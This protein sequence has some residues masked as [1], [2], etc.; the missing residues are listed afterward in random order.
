MPDNPLVRELLREVFESNRTPEDVCAS[1]PDLLTEVRHQLKRVRNLEAQLA[2]LFPSSVDELATPPVT[3]SHLSHDLPDIPGYQVE[4][5]I[6]QG[7]MGVVLRA[8][9]LKLNR[10]IALKM[11]LSGAFASRPEKAR[12][13]REAE[14]VATLSHPHIVQIYDVGELERRPFFTME[15][16]E[17]GSLA[18]QLA[19]VP[20]PAT[21]SAQLTATLALAVAYAHQ[22]GV[23]H[24][25][26]K[27][28]NI[29]HTSDNTPK[30]VDFGLARLDDSTQDLTLSGA[31]LG[32]PSY[33]SPE[34]ARGSTRDIG[35]PTDIY[36]LGAILYEM[37]T[38]R[39]PFRADTAAETVRQVVFEEPA[40]PSRLNASVPR[41][42]ETICLK[43]L[44]KPLARRYSSATEVA[45][46][47]QRFLEGQPILARPV[48]RFVRM[49]KWA[50]RR[51]AEAALAALMVL[52]L[53]LAVA[54]GFWF[55][56]QRSEQR[57]VLARQEGRASQALEDAL[58]NAATYQDQGSWPTAYGTLLDAE[59]FLAESNNPVLE[60]TFRQACQDAAT[61]TALED[62]RM[63]VVQARHSR[64][65]THPTAGQLYANAFRRYGI[66]VSSRS[67]DATAEQI[68]ESKIREPLLTFLHDWLH[69]ASDVDRNELEA[70]L[71]IA[72]DNQWRRSMR[73]A[74]VTDNSNQLNTLARTPNAAIQPAIVFS[75]LASGLR[76]KARSEDVLSLLREV[77]RRHTEDFWIH[78]L[79]GDYLLQDNPL[80]AVASLTA[81]VSIRPKSVHAYLLLGRALRD[82]GDATGAITAFRMAIALDPASTGAQDMAN[83]LTTRAD[84][85]EARNVWEKSL[86]TGPPDHNRWFGYAELC[87]FL[88]NEQAYAEARRALLE[89]P[90]AED[91]FWTVAERYS[92]ACLLRP[93]EGEDLR[94]V[95]ALVE[96]ATARGPKFP[97]PD[98]AYIQ[99]V[100]GLTQ[101]RLGQFQQAIPL[102]A[103]SSAIL[104][105]RPGPRLALA[106]AQ[107]RAGYVAEARKSLA[108]AIR[109]FNW[110]EPQAKS[111]TAWTSQVLRREAEA[112]IFPDLQAVLDGTRSPRDDEERTALLGACQ[113]QGQFALAAQSYADIIKNNPELA[114]KL[115]I[116]CRLRGVGLQGANKPFEVLNWEFRYLAARCAALAG[117]GLG[118]DGLMLSDKQRAEFRQQSR[119]W[120]LADLAAWKK[121]QANGSD[122][123]CELTRR[124]L[125]YWEVDPDL[126]TIRDPRALDKLPRDERE[127]CQDL[128]RQV[129]EARDQ[130]IQL[131]TGLANAVEPRT[132]LVEQR[133]LEEARV[134]WQLD[135]EA[136]P[137]EPDAWNAY[138]E[139]CLFLGHDD[140]F[141]R[142]RR[143]LLVKF[144]GS[145]EDSL[146]ERTG[147]ACLLA[148]SD[149]VA[150]A[151]AVTLINRIA[152]SRSRADWTRP[153]YAFTEALC[154]YRQGRFEQA[155]V[156][157][158]GEAAG[159]YGPAPGLVIA[160][161]QEKSGHHTEAVETLASAIMEYDWRQKY[162][163][164]PATWTFNVLR[165][166]AEAAILPHLPEYLECKWQPQNNSER[167]TLLGAC[168]FHD[169]WEAAA[170][171]YA[172]A[173]AADPSLAERLITTGFSRFPWK[174]ATMD[175]FDV[176][177][178]YSR[179]GAARCATLASCRSAND[180]DNLGE[181]DRIRWR[182]Q[183]LEWLQGDLKVWEKLLSTGSA[184]E[185]DI[186]KQMLNRWTSDPDLASI[187]EADA[188]NCVP[189]DQADE[190]R[191]FWE[192]V[193]VALAAT[194]P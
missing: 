122:N 93:A 49:L 8:R 48:G 145:P 15:L 13:I 187:R 26:L 82:T 80:D 24:R 72:D 168:Q 181:E 61:V 191:A 100:E 128:W 151:T 140:D 37:L 63:R 169:R 36:A 88:N 129:R 105:N 47:L 130:T 135:L 67:P 21:K 34:Q 120:L 107:F 65:P 14:A 3:E 62:I 144:G 9:H 125:T 192:A 23:V 138:A 165:R 74:L 91:D 16:L 184:M 141:R 121:I 10:F 149:D 101:Y 77:Q 142:A 68:K 159:V 124:M 31:R 185:R 2:D 143:A 35:P 123:D 136:D 173:F 164:D 156:Q 19:G 98:N 193:K 117:G 114:D 83:T 43:C 17:G 118:N 20:Q 78:Y 6:G 29:L 56:R 53:G 153:F 64:T 46:D 104:P 177:C 7:G 99:F 150:L 175:P 139:L 52:L 18:Q 86:A 132:V 42:L 70:V 172:D 55:E 189:A 190:C 25:D 160:L 90:V 157:I 127:H 194:D 28:G 89:R 163:R 95:L 116:E 38:G 51:P 112:T 27:P 54:G 148:P 96:R 11:L 102:L 176:L 81:A 73:L 174:Q 154:S 126:S 106:M 147:R 71:E 66:N 188:L 155:I 111:I 44:Q 134:R 4:E 84:L 59:R 69:E 171:L 115:T 94:R 60:R 45:D 162:T 110:Q 182:R 108:A 166:E 87:L 12:F 137:P 109:G 50:R 180:R 146:A 167:L 131:A 30:I 76:E 178:A 79:V 97:D 39:P 158:R 57:E 179:F 22:H 113:L 119:N 103:E 75:G 32:T 41:D 1:H 5:V 186:A 152:E 40:R 33:M 133:R 92:L 170:R 58:K 161:A 183:A 85:H